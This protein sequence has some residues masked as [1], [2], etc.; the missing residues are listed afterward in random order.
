MPPSSSEVVNVATTA[1][2]TALPSSL[3]KLVELEMVNTGASLTTVTLALSL[4]DSPPTL[5]SLG[6]NVYAGSASPRLTKAAPASVKT[7]V[8]PSNA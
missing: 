1:S 4:T 7:T 2:S 8:L 6:V 3:L 5:P